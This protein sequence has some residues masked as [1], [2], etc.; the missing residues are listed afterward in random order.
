MNKMTSLK[1]IKKQ[2]EE[3][4]LERKKADE[5]YT[6][7]MMELH[8]LLDKKRKKILRKVS[9]ELQDILPN[10]EIKISPYSFFTQDVI[11]FTID[12]ETLK[13]LCTGVDNS[14]EDTYHLHLTFDGYFDADDIY[15]NRLNILPKHKN[16]I[17]L[18][19]KLFE[20]RELREQITNDI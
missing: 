17:Q 19:N 3:I 2:L 10:I 16:L 4:Y 1:E 11:N 13:K 15:V 14:H 8:E 20:I 12:K 5:I 9:N 6:A 7:D 18:C